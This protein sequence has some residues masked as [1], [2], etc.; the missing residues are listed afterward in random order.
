MHFYSVVGARPQFV[1]LAPFSRAIRQ[2]FEET[3]IHT[4]QHYDTNMSAKFFE[5]LDIPQAD[6]NLGVGSGTQAAQTAAMM[7]GLEVVFENETPDLVVVF[8]DTNSTLAGA[9][10]AS[11]LGIPVV[12]VEAG[13][14]SFNRTMP[15][16]LNRIVADHCSDLLFAPTAMAVKNLAD[17]GLTGRT[18]LTGDIMADAVRDNLEIARERSTVLKRLQLEGTDFVLLTLHR[19]YTVDDPATLQKVLN[20]VANSGILV[21]FPL[22]PRTKAVIDQRGVAIGDT[23]RLIEPQGYLDFLRLQQAAQK[24]VTDSGGIQKEAYLIGRPCITVRPETEWVETVDAGWNC[25]VSPLS[26]DLA[27]S[28]ANFQPTGERPDLF[29]RGVAATMAAEIGKFWDAHQLG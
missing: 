2:R 3:V 27:E 1:K 9:I 21:V 29:G 12:H 8:G 24:I 15:E 23:I 20:A 11:K 28:I 22:H 4:G 10:S 14:R 17:E 5:D 19:P 13:L 16:E 7:T 25:L 18:V 6:Y 26:P